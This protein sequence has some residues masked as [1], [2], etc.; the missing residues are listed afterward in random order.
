M[1]D[2]LFY[3]M[4]GLWIKSPALIVGL[5]L[6]IGI[7]F[8]L[9]FD[10]RYACFSAGLILPLLCHPKHKLLEQALLLAATFALGVLW[11][12]TSIHQHQATT[13]PTTGSALFSIHNVQL[14]NSLF[15]SSYLYKG[16]LT[17][18]QSEEGQE[19]YHIPCQIYPPKGC[20]RPL[21]NC[22][23]FIQGNLE[24]SDKGLARLQSEDPWQK[25]AHSFSYAEM[26]F[27]AKQAFHSFIFAKIKDRN[28]AH[29][30]YSLC[31]GELENKIMAKEF[32]KLGLQHILAVSGFHFSLIAVFCS[33]IL[34]RLMAR[35]AAMIGLIVCLSLYFFF[36]GASPSVFRAWIAITVWSIGQ[37]IGRKSNGLNTLGVCLIIEL[38]Y[39]A[40]SIFHIGFQF[41][42]LCTAALL[43]L[44]PMTLDWMALILPKRTPEQLSYFPLPDRISYLACCFLRTSS[45]VT[46]SVHIASIP[47]CFYHFQ[48]FPVLSLLYNLFFPFCT[49]IS[50]F[51]LL[52]ALVM[53]LL[54]PFLAGL[55]H[56]L[57]TVLTTYLLGV[58]EHIPRFLDYTFTL[59][60]FD[61]FY[62]LSYL[63]I[64]L[65][66]ST[67][68]NNKNLNLL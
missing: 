41:S 8:S 19:M 12:S 26:R 35:K 52:S 55:I 31:T 2:N 60:P 47:L 48:S 45:A 9:H 25:I 20:E 14:Q 66:T 68:V 42:F 16:E 24:I 36:L 44:T 46:L 63:F 6:L 32:G 34:N 53:G 27:Q 43:I 23:Y 29:F 33:F 65:I 57:N 4:R 54:F 3:S 37:L 50:L 40:Q 17:Y 39:N 1:I 67:C 64:L 21:A 51:L 38:L 15:Y 56:S 13:T 22:S 58:T 30:L 18:F 11:G 62:I 49:G 59:P 61:L 28:A 5:H 10:W 7:C